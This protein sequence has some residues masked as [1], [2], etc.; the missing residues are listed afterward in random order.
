MNEARMSNEAYAWLSNL[1]KEIMIKR[2]QN[3]VS[4][5]LKPH[6]GRF[7]CLFHKK[8]LEFL[9]TNLELEYL[10]ATISSLRFC[11][12]KIKVLQNISWNHNYV[13]SNGDTYVTA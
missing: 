6:L 4:T 13:S 5:F 2:C 12:L 1:A 10:S 8:F 9:H 7:L 3:G 11:S